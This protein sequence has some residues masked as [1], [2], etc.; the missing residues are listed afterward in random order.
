[1]EVSSTHKK[2]AVRSPRITQERLMAMRNAADVKSSPKI[3]FGSWLK[4]QI[5]E[6]IAFANLSAYKKGDECSTRGH[7]VS[8]Y[9]SYIRNCICADCGHK[10]TS[11]C[12]LR[13]NTGAIELS[14]HNQ[15]PIRDRALPRRYWVDE[16]LAGSTTKAGIWHR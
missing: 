9:K 13:R 11:S 16:S 12:E 6:L 14:T 5:E 7:R 3:T 15:P 1:M 8:I 10:I 4:D 2:H